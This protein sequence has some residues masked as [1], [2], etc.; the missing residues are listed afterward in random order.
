MMARSSSRIGSRPRPAL[1]AL[2]I[3]ILVPLAWV[4]WYLGSPLFVDR[5]VDE[6]SPIGA[7]PAAG[8]P[9]DAKPGSTEPVLLSRGR[10]GEIDAIHKGEGTAT[11]FTLAGGR[12]GL[13]FEEFRVTNGPDLYVY[14]SGHPAPR[15]S[16]QLHEGAA[17]EVARLKGNVGNQNYELPADLDLTGFSSVV[18]YCKAFSTVF[19]TAE[20]ASAV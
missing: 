18:I 3:A 16:G 11:L 4:A 19:S 1:L 20:L 6:R 15:D 8:R 13:Q 5:V 14:L 7:A 2:A 12:A 17:L 9:A 10:F